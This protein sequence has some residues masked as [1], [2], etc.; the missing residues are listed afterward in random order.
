MSSTGNTAWR[1]RIVGSDTVP[2]ASLVPNPKNPRK[3]PEAQL[4]ALAGALS[5]IGHI[6]DVIVNRTTGR[7]IDGHA[8]VK[9][10][11]ARGETIPVKYVELSE[12]EELLALATFDPLSAMAGTDQD[13]LSGLCAE[14]PPVDDAGLQALLEQLAGK[15][16]AVE[17]END[18]PR[19]IRGS[20][21][22]ARRHVAVGPA[23]AAVRRR[24]GRD[25]RRAAAG[26][27]E[28]VSHGD[29]PAVRG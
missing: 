19:A 14:L 25:G 23:S 11:A 6:Q 9:L 4:K 26:W 20:R 10:A 5:E 13:L 22:A 12:K 2:A 18:V 17:G 28:A 16:T 3:H 24:H 15:P 27:C 8:R 7:I 1:N 29:G 21:L